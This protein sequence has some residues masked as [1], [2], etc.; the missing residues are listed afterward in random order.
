MLENKHTTA[1]M[2]LNNIQ[3]FNH[4]NDLKTIGF[5]YHKRNKKRFFFPIVDTLRNYRNTHNSLMIG[6]KLMMPSNKST[7]EWAIERCPVP[8]TEEDEKEDELDELEPHDCGQ[9]NHNH[10]DTPFNSYGDKPIPMEKLR[11]WKKNKYKEQTHVNNTTAPKQKKGVKAND[12]YDYIEIQRVNTSTYNA[13]LNG[14]LT[15]WKDHFGIKHQ[16]LIVR[17]NKHLTKKGTLLIKCFKLESN[18]I[19]KKFDQWKAEG[20]IPYDA[21]IHHITQSKFRRRMHKGI[22]MGSRKSTITGAKNKK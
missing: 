17:K 16:R 20:L 9:C 6:W 18:S 2:I 10:K 22:P 4:N 15:L 1:I 13:H 5:H 14:R 11:K 12:M 8:Q 19:N 7:L 3:I 21:K